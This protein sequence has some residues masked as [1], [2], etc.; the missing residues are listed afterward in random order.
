MLTRDKRGF[1]LGEE[2]LKIVIAVICIVFL[3]YLLVAVYFNI[4]GQQKIKEAQAILNGE[5]GIATEI[6]RL[7][8][9]GNY[10]AQGLVVPNPSDWFLF[11]F[12]EENAKPN[13]CIQQN[14][15][16]VCEEAIPDL[17]DW[18]I[19]RCDEKGVCFNVENLQ[20]FEKIKI[21]KAGITISIQKL[22]GKIVITKR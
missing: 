5:H 22:N 15:I 3:I 19:K 10:S 13:S 16:C 21:E 12:I 17:F 1:L 4:T 6:N 18:Q 8:A 2:T 11:S 14:C 9:G 20:K 7:N